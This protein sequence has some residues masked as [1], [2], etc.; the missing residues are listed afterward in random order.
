MATSANGDLGL[1][2][3]LFEP[4]AVLEPMRVLH[5][6]SLTVTIADV[7]ELD[8]VLGTHVVGVSELAPGSIATSHTEVFRSHP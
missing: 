7:E 2:I 8:R 3:E 6:P 1:C 5:H 4:I